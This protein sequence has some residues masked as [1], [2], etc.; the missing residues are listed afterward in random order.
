M[1][2]ARGLRHETSLNEEG[3]EKDGDAA[4]DLRLYNLPEDRVPTPYRGQVTGQLNL[5]P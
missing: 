2:F 3:G 4:G 1:E 5:K